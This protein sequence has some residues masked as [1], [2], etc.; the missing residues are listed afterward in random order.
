VSGQHYQSDPV[1]VQLVM[2]VKRWTHSSTFP[3]KHHC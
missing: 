2:S 3:I 1:G